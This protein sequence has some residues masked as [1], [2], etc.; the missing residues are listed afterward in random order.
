MKKGL[1][2]LKTLPTTF[3][4]VIFIYPDLYTIFSFLFLHSNAQNSNFKRLLISCRYQKELGPPY[5]RKYHVEPL[6]QALQMFE[7]LN[8]FE[9]DE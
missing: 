1:W 5:N 4:L 9:L 3:L 2:F 6:K 8:R 7:L